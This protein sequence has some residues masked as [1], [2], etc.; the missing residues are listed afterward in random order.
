MSS[1]KRVRRIE[2][3]FEH[4]DASQ[5]GDTR[6][7]L[8]FAWW[9]IHG[10]TTTYWLETIVLEEEFRRMSVVAPGESSQLLDSSRWVVTDAH[11]PTVYD[12]EDF[13][14]DGG[15]PPC[16][17]VITRRK[18]STSNGVQVNEEGE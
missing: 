1:L 10:K 8:K 11:Q 3:R 12:M 5:E 13:G 14:M 9:P 16:Y 6:R 15:G 7:R 2:M 4:K 17:S 18:K